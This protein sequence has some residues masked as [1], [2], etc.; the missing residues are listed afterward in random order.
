MKK[1]ISIIGGDLRQII[2]ADMLQN[3]GF[4]T[5]VYGFEKHKSEKKIKNSD[6]LQN[7]VSASA[8][9]LPLPVSYDNLTINAPFSKEPIKIDD[10]IKNIPDNS[11][12][13]GGKFNDYL[14]GELDSHK[15]TYCDY[16]NREELIVQNAVPTAEGAIDIALSE[17]PITLHSCNALI[18]GYGRI[19]K[20]LAKMLS[21][22][23]AN[24]TVAARRY[25]S[26]A[27]I[28]SMGYIPVNICNI[29][30][31]I[32]KYD[33][34]FNTIPSIILDKQLLRNINKKCLI[35]DLAS[36]PGGVDFDM[37][38]QLGLHVI[39]ALS[40]PGKAAPVTSGKIIKDT[41]MNII[42]EMGWY[43]ELE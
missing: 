8:V 3:S 1:T 6:S 11:I 41:I 14:L 12:L 35:I 23:D 42:T 32:H 24:V 10:I 43:N 28:D 5:N 22:F 9:I 30:D 16:F 36:K 13:L 15:I 21:G 20:I 2:L 29:Q 19:G 17:M 40:L 31:D 25:E 27:W 34:I 4:D 18:L 38:Q 33:V 7:A 26:L 37:A 39:W